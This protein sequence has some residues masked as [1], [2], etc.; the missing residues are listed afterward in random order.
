MPMDG[1]TK[2]QRTEEGGW[3]CHADHKW[4]GDGRDGGWW[5]SDEW[6][7][8]RE[9]QQQDRQGRRGGGQR[10]PTP[11]PPPA[12][13]SDPASPPTGGGKRKTRRGKTK[14]AR[15]AESRGKEDEQ[16]PCKSVPDGHRVDGRE[17]CVSIKV[18]NA[19][20][21]EKDA[22]EGLLNFLKHQQ[23]DSFAMGHLCRE[24]GPDRIVEAFLA[25][26]LFE[27]SQ[28]IGSAPVM[29]LGWPA[30]CLHRPRLE[31]QVGPEGD[32]AAKINLP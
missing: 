13:E 25:S 29:V 14:D 23:L 9:N 31:E 20:F 21:E 28:A 12:A 2:Y 19:E 5:E 8:R 4:C 1:T 18:G 16:E 6:W 30:S 24:P 11:P 7:V 26:P 10:L 32:D 27:K 22:V 15:G 3:W 17:A